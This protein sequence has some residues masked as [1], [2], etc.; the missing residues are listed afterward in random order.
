MN[1]NKQI[2]LNLIATAIAFVANAAINF[3][4]S[5][6]IVSAVSE[7]AYGFIQFTN[8]FITYFTIFTIAINSMSSRFITIEYHKGDIDSAKGYYTST[9]LANILVVLIT[10]PILLVLILNI[11]SLMQISEDLVLDV[12]ML[13]FFLA[14]N[15]YLGLITT[16]LSISYYIKDKLYIQSIINTISYILKATLLLILYNVFP[17]YIAIFGLV[18][19]LITS[20]IQ[21]LNLY[22]KNKFIPEMKVEKLKIDFCK[23]KTL[24]VSGIWNSVTRVGNLLSEGLDLLLA[25]LYIGPSEMGIIAIVKTIPN[26]IGSAL[27][28]LVSVFM[29]HMTKLY[30]EEKKEELSNYIRK[31]M[32]VVGV[33]L[34]LPII[35]II[36]IGDVLFELWFPTQDSGLLQ[37]LSIIS[38][39]QWIIIGPVSIMHNVFTVV[40]KIKTNSILICI[41]GALNIL[42]V[43]ILLNLFP[44]F[45]LYIVTGVSCMLSILRNLIYTLPFGAKCVGGKWYEFFP[46]IIKSLIAILINVLLGYIIRFIL[47]P[48]GWISLIV[49]GGIVCMIGF[50]INIVVLFSNKEKKYIYDKVI[51]II[52]KKGEIGC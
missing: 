38:I 9:L 26:M 49:C 5:K 48:C 2:I 29:P 34:N 31:S 1:E 32:K 14:G 19:L 28:S 46:E 16:N 42:I 6:Y 51:N 35:C 27:N 8:T 13:L 52:G 41:T 44:T 24:I 40:N 18:T 10:L 7:E 36:V 30:A 23:I 37:I 3:L 39:S 11:E 43:Y 15:L 47:K 21:I 45:G 33:F 12:K 50:I 4:L 20:F 17:P 22:Y 25:N